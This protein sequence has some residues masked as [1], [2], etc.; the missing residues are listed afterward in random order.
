[1][2]KKEEQAVKKCVLPYHVLIVVVLVL[3]VFVGIVSAGDVNYYE[4]KNSLASTMA[5]PQ[6]EEPSSILTNNHL[7]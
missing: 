7:E 2:G 4:T 5:K 1:M 6:P 3:S